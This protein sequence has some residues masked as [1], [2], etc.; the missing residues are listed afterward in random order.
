M[1]AWKQQGL[2]IAWVDLV[3]S[4]TNGGGTA[5]VHA[6]Q[7]WMQ[8]HNFKNVY[9]MAD[10]GYKLIPPGKTSIGTPSFV[11]VD[12]RTQQVTTWQEGAYP[13]SAPNNQHK[14]VEKLAIKNRDADLAAGAGQ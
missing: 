13:E 7:V 8:K 6:A 2:N 12:P 9:V 1:A 5:D 4:N 10:P 11:I 14:V 3:V